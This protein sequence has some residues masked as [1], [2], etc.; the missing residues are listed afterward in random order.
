MNIFDVTRPDPKEHFLVP[1]MVSFLN[2]AGRENGFVETSLVYDRF[3]GL[4]FLAEQ[5]DMA[6]IRSHRK[7]LIETSAR[8]IPIIRQ[9]MPSALRATN[10]G[11]YHIRRL[12]RSFVYIDAMIV[13]TPILDKNVQQ[14][15]HDVMDILPRL[16]RAEYF[17]QYLDH[18]WSGLEH[19]WGV[20]DWH[21]IS[22]D[23]K[24][25]MASIRSKVS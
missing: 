5:I 7:K 21:S 12:C 6:I 24:T 25:D 9:S 22:A 20:F 3:Q 10:E 13:D 15:I 18:Q 11:I 23:L 2:N 17:R 8:Q 19:L 4:G 16:D 1:M 14:N